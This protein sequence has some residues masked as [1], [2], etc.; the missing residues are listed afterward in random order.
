[1]KF[2]YKLQ[3][4]CGTY[5][6]NPTIT[7]S[8]GTSGRGNTGSNI[9]YTSNGNTLISPTSNRIQIIDLSTHTVRTLPVEAR[10]NI[11][12]IALSPNDTILIAVD[13]QN[14]AMI[15]NIVRGVVLHRFKFKHRVLNAKFSPCGNYIGVTHGKHIQVWLAPN[16]LRKEFSPLILH[17]TYTGQSADVTSIQWS[18]DSSVIMACSK[19]CTVKL[20]TVHTTR[21]YQPVTLSGHKTPV[22]G[23]FFA[24][25]E[26]H[27]AN[28]T[29]A[30][31]TRKIIDSVYTMSQ[32]GALVTWKCSKS[33]DDGDTDRER[34]EEI[35]LPP[36]DDTDFSAKV[37]EA[38]DFFSGGGASL[39]NSNKKSTSGFSQSDQ[40]HELVGCQWRY[41]SRH[42]FNQDGASLVAC[43]YNERTKLLALGFSSGYF[44]YLRDA[45]RF[46]HPHAV[47]W[48]QSAHQHLC[49]Q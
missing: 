20:W 48:I 2:N 43:T 11:R 18:E 45:K 30:K 39:L 31:N 27:E 41:G 37:D 17:R 33:E 35:D 14:Y 5:Y 8:Y 42:Y 10:S 21:R 4:L 28:S 24:Y 34:K 44:W 3:R 40:A 19:D 16:H 38:V 23:A 25:R 15:V 13:V 9:L 47:G 7:D 29:A 49:P 12:T 22:V 36:N 1:M 46:E 26:E 32:D 6:G